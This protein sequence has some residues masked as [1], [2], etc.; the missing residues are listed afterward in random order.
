MSRPRPVPT[1]RTSKP[2][3][4]SCGRST[5]AR[6][7]SGPF[8]SSRKSGKTADR[9]RGYAAR[10]RNLLLA[11]AIVLF[12]AGAAAQGMPRRD[13]GVMPRDRDRPANAAPIAPSDPFS[14]LERELPSLEVDLLLK[15]AQLSAWRVF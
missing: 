8:N 13:R 15:E 4:A 7:P 12:A 2:S 14:A 3:G 10:M 6:S 1:R 9:D 5:S 11:A